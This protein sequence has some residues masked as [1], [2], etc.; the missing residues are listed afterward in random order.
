MCLNPTV[1]VSLLS[2]ILRQA[3]LYA[4]CGGKNNL[5]AIHSLLFTT[6]CVRLCLL[7][8]PGKC[9]I[10]PIETQSRQCNI[11]TKL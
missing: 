6:V 5:N 3:V 11:E 1:D 10:N 7:F 4:P 9:I 8:Q 2:L